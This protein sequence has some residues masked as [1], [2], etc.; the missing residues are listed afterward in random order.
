MKITDVLVTPL[1]LPLKTPYV[2]S[3]GV[4]E[5]FF[6]NLIEMVGEDGS[7]GIGET[8]TAPDAAAQ[9][10]VL[11]KIGKSFIGQSVFDASRIMASAYRQHFLV[12]GGN[13]PRYANQLMCGF[14]LAALYL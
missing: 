3:Q 4:E 9:A 8:T 12:Y 11:R 13:L 6:V 2:W 1:A 7:I 5:V 10:Q 14:D